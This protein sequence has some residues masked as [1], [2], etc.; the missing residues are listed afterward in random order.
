MLYHNRSIVLPPGLAI[1][2]Y[3]TQPNNLHIY[4]LTRTTVV[5]VEYPEAQPCIPLQVS[6]EIKKSF[7]SQYSYTVLS[8]TLFFP[9]TPRTSSISP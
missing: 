7:T 3:K 9:S 8:S 2:I 5:H 6:L 4:S 1:A